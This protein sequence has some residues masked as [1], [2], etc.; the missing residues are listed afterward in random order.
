M[1][2]V[3][4]R[5]FHEKGWPEKGPFVFK[6]RSF[7]IPITIHKM[8]MALPSNCVAVS[9]NLNGGPAMMIQAERAARKKGIRLLWR[10]Y[11]KKMP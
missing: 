4:L 7:D 6:Q 10:K 2:T 1:K 11:P 8:I 5:T 3:N 9:V